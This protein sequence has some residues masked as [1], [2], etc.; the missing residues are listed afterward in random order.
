MKKIKNANQSFAN[1]QSLTRQQ[2]KRVMGGLDTTTT[3]VKAGSS[4]NHADCCAGGGMCPSEE[5]AHCPGG[6]G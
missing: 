6:N 3:C 1:A 4:C 5:D 2:L